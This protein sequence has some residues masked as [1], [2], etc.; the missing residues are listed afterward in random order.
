MIGIACTEGVS[1]KD[2]QKNQNNGKTKFLYNVRDEKENGTSGVGGKDILAE[3]NT[4]RAS[5]DYV[6]NW[7]T[8]TQYTLNEYKCK[9]ITA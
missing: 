8:H 6:G 1:R 9:Y 7:Y 4:Q 2:E 5:I 3:E